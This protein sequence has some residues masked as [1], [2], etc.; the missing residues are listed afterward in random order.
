MAV[1]IN[2]ERCALEYLDLLPIIS[3]GA[4]AGADNRQEWSH[5]LDAHWLQS[6]FPNRIDAAELLPCLVVV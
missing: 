2:V 1:G 6:T 3:Q 5:V 4:P